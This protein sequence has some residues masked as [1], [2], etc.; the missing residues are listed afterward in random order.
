MGDIMWYSWN[1]L[2]SF[3]IWHNEVK[4]ILGIPYPNRNSATNE[5]DESAQW[6]VSYTDPMVITSSDIRAYVEE[7]IAIL[8]SKHLGI[9]SEQFIY[10]D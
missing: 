7:H 3:E 9:P 4:N 1:S 5:I 10:E 6:T 8:V 2:D